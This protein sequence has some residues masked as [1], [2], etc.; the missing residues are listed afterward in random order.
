MPMK[1]PAHPGS[2]LRAELEALNATVAEA[3]EELGVTRQQLYNVLNGK[4]AVTA[5]MA[6][7]LE[8]VVGSTADMW[9]RM[10]VNYDLAQAR[11][12]NEQLKLKR[13]TAKPVPIAAQ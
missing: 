9:L 8:M 13:L 2:I 11:L 10:Q 5:D 4:S 3:A 7:R 6:L 12:R 1:N